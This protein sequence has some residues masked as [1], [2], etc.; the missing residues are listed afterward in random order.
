MEGSKWL[1]GWVGG[2]RRSRNAKEDRELGREI[3][4]VR[5]HA[6]YNFDRTSLLLAGELYRALTIAFTLLH[7]S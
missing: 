7:F 2:A 6:I 4:W 1:D 5:F 3:S